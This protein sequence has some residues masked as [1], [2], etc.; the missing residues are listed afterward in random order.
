MESRRH[1]MRTFQNVLAN[2]DVAVGS[3]FCAM[4]AQRILGL[5]DHELRELTLGMMLLGFCLV[6]IAHELIGAIRGKEQ[7]QPEPEKPSE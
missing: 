4:A 6:L 1:V 2:L 5:N 7:P 3:L